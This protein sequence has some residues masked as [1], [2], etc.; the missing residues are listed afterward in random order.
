[1]I[2]SAA[3]S[4]GYQ[5]TQREKC[6]GSGGRVAHSNRQSYATSA[7]SLNVEVVPLPFSLWTSMVP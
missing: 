1:M 5:F 2:L 4:N 3:I 7:G 6:Y